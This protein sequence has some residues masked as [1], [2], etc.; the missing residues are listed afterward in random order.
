MFLVFIV[1]GIV[2]NYTRFGRLIT[3]I[4]SNEE[5]V[6]LAGIAVPATSWPST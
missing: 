4:G 1:G 6:R 2:L 5:A 3:A